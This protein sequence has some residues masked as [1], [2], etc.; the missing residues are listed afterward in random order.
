MCQEEK[1][2]IMNK[3][4]LLTVKTSKKGDYKETGYSIKLSFFS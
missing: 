1:K 3:I 2:I 4:S